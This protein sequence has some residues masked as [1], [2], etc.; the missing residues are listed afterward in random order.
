MYERKLIKYHTCVGYQMHV[1]RAMLD[2]HPFP[3][4][5]LFHALREANSKLVVVVSKVQK[6]L[7]K[8]TETIDKP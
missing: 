2:K 5:K 6:R 3:I 7:L 1:I 4:V 8:K